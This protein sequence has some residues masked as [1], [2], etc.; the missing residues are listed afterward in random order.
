MND[1]GNEPR[2]ILS[3]GSEPHDQDS[4]TMSAV[5]RLPCYLVAFGRGNSGRAL[6][7]G[8]SANVLSPRVVG[9]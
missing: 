4:Q 8:F 3:E 6:V 5:S 7:F 9:C 2:G 1:F